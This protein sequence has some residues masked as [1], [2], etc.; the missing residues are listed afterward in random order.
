[1]RKYGDRGEGEEGGMAGALVSGLGLGLPTSGRGDE[2]AV[3]A[4]RE[5]SILG[6]GASR[7]R[8]RAGTGGGTDMSKISVE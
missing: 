5:V 4:S 1:M 6:G 3:R 7:R 2:A 8:E